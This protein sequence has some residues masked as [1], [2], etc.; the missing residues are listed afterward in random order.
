VSE[1]IEEDPTP[2]VC[3]IAGA[4][5]RRQ[6]EPEFT[7]TT[8]E[9]SA[10]GVIRDKS[11]PQAVTL[12]LGDGG[13]H[14][15]HGAADGADATLV[16]DLGGGEDEP[17]VSGGEEHPG[18]VEW[19]AALLDPP[20]VDWRLAA[21]DFWRVASARS[22]APA[23]FLVHETESDET[24]LLGAKG[25]APYEIHGPAEAL[26]AVFLGQLP[27]TEAVV[28]EAVFVR[29]KLVELS[30]LTGAGFAIMIGGGE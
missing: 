24:V 28:R 26:C 29:G 27:L 30:V 1:T 12:R 19:L 15:E 10:V 4:L 16:V 14:L 9:T 25:P 5:R 2:L 13:V 6:E 3:L 11:T 8:P 17:E 23:G 22:G 21:E 18:L 7:R 20:A